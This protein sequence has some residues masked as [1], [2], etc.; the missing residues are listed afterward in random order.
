MTSA[1][2]GAE[3]QHRRHRHHHRHYQEEGA[4]DGAG[5]ECGEVRVRVPPAPPAAALSLS[6]PR[7][8]DDG[9]AAADDSSAGQCCGPENEWCIGVGLCV[10]LM[11]VMIGAALTTYLHA[12][13]AHGSGAEGGLT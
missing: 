10:A 13:H 1:S 9:A 7:R 2:V 5:E 8:Y 4:G 3:R 12:G 6:P 11:I